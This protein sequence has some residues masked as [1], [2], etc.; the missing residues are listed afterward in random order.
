M[1]K[2]KLVMLK[3][4]RAGILSDIPFSEKFL[5]TPGNA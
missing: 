1:E 3:D 5:I 4:E 2:W